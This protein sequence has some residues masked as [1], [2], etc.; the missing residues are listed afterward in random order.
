MVGTFYDRIQTQEE[1]LKINEI[2]EDIM[3]PEIHRV[4][5]NA[6]LG[7]YFYPVDNTN[8]KGIKELRSEIETVL[9]RQPYV[10]LLT[11]I[12]LTHPIIILVKT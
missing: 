4:I 7:L 6:E 9:Q 12:M 2:L 1:L 8:K 10:G 3:G 11:L 5:S